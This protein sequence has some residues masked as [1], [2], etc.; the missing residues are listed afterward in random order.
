MVETVNPRVASQKVGHVLWD[1]AITVSLRSWPRDPS[2]AFLVMTGAHD[3]SRSL[4]SLEVVA[5]WLNE[6]AEFGYSHIR[7]SAVAPSMQRVLRMVGFEVCQELSLLRATTPLH[8]NS[9]RVVDL[10]PRKMRHFGGRMQESARAQILGVDTAAFGPKWA[11]DAMSLRDALLATQRSRIF[12]MTN[13]RQCEGFIV[14]AH[15]GTAGFVQRLA[16]QPHLWHTGLGSLLLAHGLQ[17]LERQDCEHVVVN[18][19][20]SNVGALGL[21]KKFG[22]QV[23]P[24]EL[25]VLERTTSEQAT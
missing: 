19:E 7:T 8:T 3:D 12:S 10:R 18:T 5:G 17:W 2:T 23:M 9:A 25:T 20:T 16:V 6:V 21:Y 14:V 22:F 4:P 13:N 1:G 11:L 24:Y 15:T